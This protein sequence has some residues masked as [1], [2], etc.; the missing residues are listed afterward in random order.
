[1][2]LTIERIDTSLPMPTYAHEGDAGFDLYLAGTEDERG[3]LYLETGQ[4]VV[5][6]VGIKLSIPPN[7][8]VQIRPRSSMSKRGVI[9][10]FGTVDEGYTGE[11][12]V[13]LH[14]NGG[15]AIALLYGDRIAQA[16]LAP[17]TRAHIVEG[18]VA[19]DTERGEGGFGSTGK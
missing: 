18:V 19:C 6:D 17:V 11:V 4:T 1:M 12:K 13:V 10:Q 14:N 7:H 15:H 5:A 8:E 2:N 3:G 9:A 16:V